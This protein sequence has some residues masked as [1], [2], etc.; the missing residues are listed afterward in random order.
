VFEMT[1]TEQLKLAQSELTIR[2]RE[3]NTAQRNLNRVLA[4][5]TY[6]EKRIELARNAKATDHHDGE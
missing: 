2:Q 3:F 6:L 1:L 4:Q 5:I